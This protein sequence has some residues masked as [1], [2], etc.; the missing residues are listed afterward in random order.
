MFSKR[1]IFYWNNRVC[2]ILILLFVFS[3]FLL[4][5]FSILFHNQKHQKI[6]YN[7]L[8]QQSSH[9]GEHLS[10]RLNKKT[11]AREIIGSNDFEINAT[12][13]GNTFDGYNLLILRELNSGTLTILITSMNGTVMQKLAMGTIFVRTA[14]FINSTTVMIGKNSGG[15]I[16]W[17]IYNNVTHNIYFS[18]HHHDV[19]YNPLNE[20]FLTFRRY[21]IDINGSNYDF[22][23]ID[24][25]N[26][27][28]HLVWSLDT[29]SFISYTQWC[30]FMD[31]IGDSADITHSNSIFFDV[32]EDILYYNSRN[33][34]TFYKID[35]KTGKVLWGLGEYGNF[36]LF[37]RNNNPREELFYHAHSVEKVDD[38]TFILF[39]ND[40]H[41]QTNQYNERSRILE[42]TINETTM[43]ANESWSWTAPPEYYSYIWGDADRLPNGNRLGTF[44]TWTHPGTTIQARLVEVDD[45]GRIVWELNFPGTKDFRYGVYR[46]ERFRFSPILSSPL[47]LQIS[48]VDNVSVTWQTWYNFRTRK[49]MNGS[50]IL[51]LDGIPIDSGPHIFNKFWCPNNLTFDMSQL[52]PGH[53]NLTLELLDEGGHI[54][55][56]NVNIYV[57]LLVNR[58]PI[59]NL[60][61]IEKGNNNSLIRWDSLENPSL[62][63]NITLNKTRIASFLWNNSVSF[64]LN[65]LSVGTYNISFQL[66]NNTIILDEDNFLAIIYPSLPPAVVLSPTNQKIMWNETLIL[67]W[68]FF[69]HS[70]SSWNIFLNDTLITSA[71]WVTT[72][73]QL[74]WIV[75]VLDE[76]RYNVTLTVDDLV[77]YQSQQ[78]TW[79][80]V[81][82][83]NLPFFSA[84]PQQ[85]EF[86]WGEVNASLTWEVHGGTQWRLWRNCTLVRSGTYSNKSITI[87]IEHWQ[88]ERWRLGHYNITLQVYDE[89]GASSSNTLIILIW[90]N[91]G[92]KYADAII[93]SS[94]IWYSF[95]EKALGAPDGTFAEIFL[96]YGNGYLSLD[97]GDTEEIIN[98]DRMDVTIVA[99]GGNY[100]VYVKND[101]NSIF[102]Y[103][104][105]GNDNTSFD[106]GTIG[107]ST[108]RYIR[109][110]YYSGDIVELDAI[111]ASYYN[112]PEVDNIPPQINGPI[113]FWVWENQTMVVLTWEVFDVTPWNYALRINGALIE[114]KPWNGSNIIFTLNLINKRGQI[115]VSL[116]LYDIFKNHAEDE[117]NIE[118]RPLESTSTTTTTTTTSAGRASSA[119]VLFSSVSLICLASIIGSKQ[120]KTMK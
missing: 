70:P 107:V 106:L 119:G 114:S 79:L 32:E 16:L 20:T 26:K 24:E 40:L 41:N 94:S 104:G 66:F 97:M 88:F 12:S 100:N 110:E 67:T 59:G 93:P 96:D 102:R 87:L 13:Q 44:G 109:V 49:Q 54:T 35:H 5:H 51:Y 75:P 31:Y 42:V 55:T 98:G 34:N 53:Y 73:Y 56:D 103:L 89:T 86:Q 38:H 105:W 63:C 1:D 47:D 17:D 18:A 6:S 116:V 65:S 14:K 19:E 113:D 117:V 37:D 50:F 68:E 62:T 10:T 36:S 22:D 33:T 39:D 28:G 69:D 90:I 30:P 71:Q 60:I 112:E 82:P 83:P 46:I 27:T 84:S 115:Q 57:N 108:A 21:T 85:K 80:T 7:N 52:E 111:V 11:I 23:T 3:G 61:T 92:D 95:G 120:K 72:S 81:L 101:I 43:T 25:Y 99:Q 78:T 29:R 118:I 2:I 64:N 91:L 15:V 45:T 9:L 4:I 77:G 8:D 48:S 76:G 58:N 74:N